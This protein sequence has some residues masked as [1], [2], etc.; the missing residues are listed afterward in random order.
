MVMVAIVSEVTKEKKKKKKRSWY[1]TLEMGICKIYLNKVFLNCK[2]N[3]KGNKVKNS[4][5]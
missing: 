5:P 1:F 2:K 4:I 3:L